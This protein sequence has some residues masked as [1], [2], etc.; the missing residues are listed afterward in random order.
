MATPTK[1]S[2]LLPWYIGTVL[3][4]LADYWVAKEL[5]SDACQAPSIISLGVVFVIPAVYL[6]LMYLT[7]T[8]EK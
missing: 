8:S 1:Q 2:R 7:L 5:F 4:A 6:V 3:I